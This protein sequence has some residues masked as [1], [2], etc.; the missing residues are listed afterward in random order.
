MKY[1]TP[2]LVSNSYWYLHIA[3]IAFRA[4]VARFLFYIILLAYTSLSRDKC[5]R[6]SPK[7]SQKDF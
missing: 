4:C 1:E 3:K 7:A 6:A 2:K 5:E